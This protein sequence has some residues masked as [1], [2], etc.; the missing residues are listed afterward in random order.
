MN[1]VEDR[2][3]PPEQV[4]RMTGALDLPEHR[5]GHAGRVEEMTLRRSLRQRAAFA[6]YRRFDGLVAPN[7]AAACQPRHERLGV[8]EIEELPRVAVEQESP[9]GCSRQCLVI[10][11]EQRAR[12]MLR[13]ERACL[14]SNRNPLTL[15]R[16]IRL[17]DFRLG[18]PERGECPSAMPGDDDFHMTR[19]D[20]QERAC[21][22]AAAPPD[23]LDEWRI[24]EA[25]FEVD[26]HAASVC[27]RR[28]AWGLGEQK[29]PK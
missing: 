18:S 16:A 2:D 29:V 4:R 1:G 27:H 15:S 10:S 14:E 26:E 3:A 8:F 9:A 25:I 11:V 20:R 17:T 19:G 5:P 24:R 12:G 6:L 23:A 13:Q 7:H 21:P 28:G 22:F